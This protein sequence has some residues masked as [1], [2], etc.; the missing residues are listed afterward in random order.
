MKISLTL[1]KFRANN[2]DLADKYLFISFNYT[3]WLDCPATTVPSAEAM[4]QTIRGK[5]SS[6]LA[7]SCGGEIH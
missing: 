6:R 7:A 4:C 1:S 2:P 3:S 5:S